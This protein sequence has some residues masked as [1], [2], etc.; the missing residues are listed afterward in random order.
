MPFPPAHQVEQQ[1][2]A[3]IQQVAKLYEQGNVCAGRLAMQLPGIAKDLQEYQAARQQPP[4]PEVNGMDEVNIGNKGGSPALVLGR[5]Q[6]NLGLP[7]Q[8][9]GRRRVMQCAGHARSV[10]PPRRTT[11]RTRMP[12]ESCNRE[13]H[14][15]RAPNRPRTH[16]G[17]QAELLRCI[18]LEEARAAAL[19]QEAAQEA[20]A[21]AAEDAQ[22]GALAACTRGLQAELEQLHEA[23]ASQAQRV[24]AKYSEQLQW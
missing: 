14:L 24:G 20:S 3:S 12:H 19:E 17:A 16:A 8:V 4:A 9:R 5:R 13:R 7:L 1:L 23:R 15:P 6:Q 10:I 2:L 21:W 18:A 22:H 11:P